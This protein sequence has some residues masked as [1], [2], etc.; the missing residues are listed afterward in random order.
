[1]K[2]DITKII[3][4][5]ERRLQMRY[6]KELPAFG[7]TYSLMGYIM[8]ICANPGLSQE[9]IA[10]LMAVEKSSV[11][12]AVRQLLAEGYVARSVNPASRRE[13]IL[14]PTEKAF[15]AP[16][17]ILA[18][19]KKVHALVTGAMTPVERELFLSLLGKI[20]LDEI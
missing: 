15:A 12:K 2:P 17:Q 9:R 19:K 7:V 6:A 8:C 13:Y 20:P 16:G 14:Q 4:V 5:L 10:A 1:M 18:V 3:A 11:A